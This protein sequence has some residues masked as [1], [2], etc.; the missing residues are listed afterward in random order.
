MGHHRAR[1]QTWQIE[2]CVTNL[3][4]IEAVER[5]SQSRVRRN[6]RHLDLVGAPDDVRNDQKLEDYELEL[7]LIG[8][9]LTLI[10]VWRITTSQ[11]VIL[12]TGKLGEDPRD[13]P[14]LE[15]PFYKVED[16]LT[17]NGLRRDPGEVWEKWL[18][19]IRKPE[20]LPM[21]RL[22]NRWRFDP[23]GISPLDKN[24]LSDEVDE[25]LNTD[26]RST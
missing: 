14:G 6:D 4:S 19:R 24:H 26:S 11:Q 9:L 22:H 25:W 23:N 18:L 1:G 21:T 17:E 5:A 16:R 3:E 2:G 12:N 8:G 10:L 15:S 20:L 7:Y 13:A